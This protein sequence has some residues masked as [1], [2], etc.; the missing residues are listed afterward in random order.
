MSVT[1]YSQEPSL[2]QERFYELYLN[3]CR[4]I[5]ATPSTKD[6]AIWFDSE[7]PDIPKPWESEL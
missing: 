5:H 1:E 7:Y 6:F 2:E 3:D 4:A